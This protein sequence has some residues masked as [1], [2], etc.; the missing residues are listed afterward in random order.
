MTAKVT[1]NCKK[2]LIGHSASIYGIAKGFEEHTFFT[3]DGNG[4]IVSWNLHKGDD[5]TLLAK[6]QNPVYCLHTDVENSI[7]WGGQLDG[8]LLR[9]PITG[10]PKVIQMHQGAIYGILNW[11]NNTLLTYGADGKLIFSLVSTSQIINSI[12]VGHSIRSVIKMADKLIIGCSGGNLLLYDSKTF[13]L[14]RIHSFEN[15][16]FTIAQTP[17]TFQVLAAGRTARLHKI[18]IIEKTSTNS[19]LPEHLQSI[20][21]ICYNATANPS[22]LASA[23]MDKTVKIWS[24]EDFE[25]L[26]V[27]NMEKFGVHGSSVN[28]LLWLSPNE[29]ISVSDDRKIGVFEIY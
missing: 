7:I 16:L 25:L 23:S 4:W 28:N 13:I 22:L 5:G 19:E 26:K 8:A 11:D 12:T 9:I 29:L 17:E 15:S 2:I 3:S 18:D 14:E 1:V 6:G 10:E 21:K 27:I 24:A 20:H